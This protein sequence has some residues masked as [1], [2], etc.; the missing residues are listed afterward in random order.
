MSWSE[1]ARFCSLAVDCYWHIQDIVLLINCFEEDFCFKS[2]IVLRATPAAI[3]FLMVL[4]PFENFGTLT[5]INTSASSS[6]WWK[7]YFLW[8]KKN[9][10]VPW[11]I[12]SVVSWSPQK[13]SVLIY[14][15]KRMILFFFLKARVKFFVPLYDFFLPCQRND[16]V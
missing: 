3:R 11:E 1:Q 2:R 15:R 4:S 14:E 10:L 13:G 6:T 8:E 9:L 12:N 16:K 5:P 7:T